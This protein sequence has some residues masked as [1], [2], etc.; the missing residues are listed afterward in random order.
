MPLQPP[1][2]DFLAKAPGPGATSVP[3]GR[4]SERGWRWPVG[5]TGFVVLVLAVLFGV[6]E[7]LV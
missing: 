5:V 2:P 1:N 6:P 7:L 3:S 4:S